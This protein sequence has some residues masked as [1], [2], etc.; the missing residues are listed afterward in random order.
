MAIQLNQIVP[1]GR[2]REEYERMFSLSASDLAPGVLD[3]GGGPAS[4]TAELNALGHRAV[5][6]DPLYA[7][8]GKDIQA[9]FEAAS[10]SMIAQIRATPGDWVWSFHRD[11]DDLLANRRAALGRFLA[12]YEQG[13]REGRYVIAELPSLP[14]DAGTFGLA[15]CSHLLFLYSDLL[16][17]EFH[18]RAIRELCR[19]AREVRIFPLL[20]LKCEPSPHLDAARARIRSEGYQSEVVPVNYELQRG[21]NRMLRV[22]R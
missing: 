3:C 11:P 7:W 9:R 17:E 8:P 15:L 16:T 12:D 22:F 5:S 6:A 20:T 2:T 4:F 13:R 14:F 18:L 1:W 10:G 21:G 19:V